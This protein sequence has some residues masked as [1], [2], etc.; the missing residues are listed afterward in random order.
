MSDVDFGLVGGAFE[1]FA[2]EEL[3]VLRAGNILKLFD[4]GVV[5][6]QAKLVEFALNMLDD[7]VLEEFAIVEEFLMRCL[8]SYSLGHPCHVMLTSIVMVETIDLV[9]PSMIPFTIS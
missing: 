8:V 9:S 7:I 2:G 5:D 6:A 4:V 1:G 3:E